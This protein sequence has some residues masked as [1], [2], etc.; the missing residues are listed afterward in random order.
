MTKLSKR[1]L[2]VY[3]GLLILLAALGAH[4]QELQSERVYLMQKK[5]ALEDERVEL[6]AQAAAV[7]GPLAV[8][9]WALEQGM[10]AV[11]QGHEATLV[12]ALDPP[13]LSTPPTGLE[14]K[15]LWR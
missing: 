9:A 15:T 1:L 2:I 10:V 8:R 14:V 7:T 11:P 13:I 3:V 5:A 12:P 6:R 4:N